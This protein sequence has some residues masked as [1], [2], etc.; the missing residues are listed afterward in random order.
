MS[1]RNAGAAGQLVKEVG[2]LMAPAPP[3]AAFGVDLRGGKPEAERSVADEP[4]E[5]SQRVSTIANT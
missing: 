2:R 4:P 5:R 3:V 1:S